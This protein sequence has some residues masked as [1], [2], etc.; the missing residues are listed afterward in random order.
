MIYVVLL[1]INP[2]QVTSDAPAMIS[3]SYRSPTPSQPARARPP[4]LPTAPPPHP[5]VPPPAYTELR[6]EL[7][8]TGRATFMSLSIVKYT[9]DSFSFVPCKNVDL[10]CQGRGVWP[11]ALAP[12]V[13]T[14]WPSCSG[15]PASLPTSGDAWHL[16]MRWPLIICLSGVSSCTPRCA[17]AAA[18]SWPSSGSAVTP[19]SSYRPGTPSLRPRGGASYH[20]ISLDELTRPVVTVYFFLWFL[21]FSLQQINWIVF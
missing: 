8:A 19:T 11:A 14:R 21:L 12:E 5:S 18:P 2:G 17:G 6:P 10:W 3:V 7:G 13:M 4:S 15:V 20:H 1:Q 9:S 16:M